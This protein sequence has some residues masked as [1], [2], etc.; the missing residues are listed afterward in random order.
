MDNHDANLAP[1]FRQDLDLVKCVDP[2]CEVDHPVFIHSKCHTGGG[3]AV[4]FDKDVGCI[5]LHCSV[6]NVLIVRIQVQEATVQ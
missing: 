6:C 3:L 2:L 5:N 1:L 4:A